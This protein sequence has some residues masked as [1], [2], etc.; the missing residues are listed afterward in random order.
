MVWDL[1][2]HAAGLGAA[3]FYRREIMYSNEL[4]AVSAAVDA[5]SRALRGE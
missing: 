2:V 3:V 4:K 1:D 5:L